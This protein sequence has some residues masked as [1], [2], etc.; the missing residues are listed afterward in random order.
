MLRAVHAIGYRRIYFEKSSR[1][2]PA[3]GDDGTRQEAF[4]AKWKAY[5]RIIDSESLMKATY[6]DYF[7]FYQALQKFQNLKCINVRSDGPGSHPAFHERFSTKDIYSELY[8]GADQPG[9]IRG[10]ALQGMI[11]AVGK[12]GIKLTSLTATV[13]PVHFFF[14]VFYSSPYLIIQVTQ[15]LKHM[16]I[17]LCPHFWKQHSPPVISGMR[18]FLSSAV[19]L[20]KL[21]VALDSFYFYTYTV[22]TMN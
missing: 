4:E 17:A 15:H 8:T 16:D 11:L 9:D 20:E 21:R 3:T 7:A 18:N 6:Y 5:R 19:N 1:F 12:A 2:T 14:P 22:P 10:W 13:I